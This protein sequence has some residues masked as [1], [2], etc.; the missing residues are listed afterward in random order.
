MVRQAAPAR[1]CPRPQSARASGISSR[2]RFAPRVAA[3]N[4]AGARRG[5]A[6]SLVCST[7]ARPHRLGD[8]DATLSRWKQGF[9]PPWGHQ[10]PQGFFAALVR[11]AGSTGAKLGPNRGQTGAKPGPNAGLSV[12]QFGR[13]TLVQSGC[14]PARGIAASVIADACGMSLRL[15]GM[16]V[17]GYSSTLFDLLD[18][19]RPG[20]PDGVGSLRGGAIEARPGALEELT[21][22][23][24]R[25]RSLDGTQRTAP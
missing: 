12:E 15:S 3:H 17:G 2:P 18:R 7:C 21:R 8:Q 23:D 24:L 10:Q 16:P 20:D 22:H 19:F 4:P 11:F 1:Q 5:C 25:A 6:R 14:G 9:E 13:R